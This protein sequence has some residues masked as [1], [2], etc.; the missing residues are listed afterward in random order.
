[1]DILLPYYI[2][3]PF[4]P[5]EDTEYWCRN[6]KN[7][8]ANTPG[9]LGQLGAEL[10]RAGVATARRRLGLGL[11][12]GLLRGADGWISLGE[13]VKHRKG[14]D[15]NGEILMWRNGGTMT[16]I[17]LVVMLRT[18]VFRNRGGCRKPHVWD[19]LGPFT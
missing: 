17:F 10:Q 7:P 4:F 1:M 8:P 12:W 14:C 11:L 13:A 9:H 2:L 16:M 18:M 15:G 6:K 19:I 5:M 3:V